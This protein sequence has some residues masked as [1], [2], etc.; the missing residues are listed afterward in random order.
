MEVTLLSGI[1]R[2]YSHQWPVLQLRDRLLHRRSP[3]RH[4]NDSGTAA[5]V[6]ILAELE[7]RSAA[8]SSTLQ[9]MHSI[10][11]RYTTTAGRA[12]ANARWIVVATGSDRHHGKTSQVT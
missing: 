11:Q 10:F 4:L 1:V 2:N 12:E 6:S 3:S 7:G 5:S 9:P 8:G